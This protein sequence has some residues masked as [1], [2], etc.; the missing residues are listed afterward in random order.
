MATPEKQF[1]WLS[2]PVS[3]TLQCLTIAP[4]TFPS[5]TLVQKIAFSSGETIPG[6]ARLAPS[7]QGSDLDFLAVDD[8]SH[9][10]MKECVHP[11]G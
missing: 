10:Y 3:P 4:V 9:G 1:I 6:N 2:R 5:F 7:L 8:W 11:L